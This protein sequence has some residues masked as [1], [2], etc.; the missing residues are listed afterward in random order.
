MFKSRILPLAFLLLLAAACTGAG[1][2]PSS[3]PASQSPPPSPSPTAQPSP[4]GQPVSVRFDF[5]DGDHGWQGG[6]SDFHDETRPDDTA[7]GIE[8]LP[9]GAPADAE[10]PALL[11]TARNNS[12]DVFM[13][14]KR[15]LGSDDGLAPDT[16]YRVSFEITFLSDAPTGCMGVGGAPGESVYLKAGATADEPLVVERDGEHVMSVDKGNQAQGGPAASVAG[17]VANGIDCGDA[18]GVEPVPFGQVTREHA[19]ETTVRTDGQVP[20][21]CWW[22]RTRVSSRRRPSITSQSS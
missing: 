7:V 2:P 20:S 18:L 6:F 11:V 17:D 1:D 14:I 4:D 21:G 13:F 22:A 8:E 12:D 5:R 3:P 15:Q 19:H 16:E 9:P 10:G